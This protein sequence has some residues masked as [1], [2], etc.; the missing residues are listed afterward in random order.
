MARF[1]MAISK[2]RVSLPGMKLTDEEEAI[3]TD[4]FWEELQGNSIEKVEEAFKWVR[5]NLKYFP[6]PIEIIEHIR[7]VNE[8]EYAQGRGQDVQRIEWM[9]PSEKGKEIATAMLRELQD[10]W[11]ED[12][13][14]K[15]V[16]R[17]EKFKERKRI[18]ENQ[19]KMLGLN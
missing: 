10:K 16:V 19:K 11:E 14:K 1:L 13:R 3:R 7:V 15:Q 9:Q 2:T 8:Y 12:E 17:E 5:G 4:V 18:L 6:Q